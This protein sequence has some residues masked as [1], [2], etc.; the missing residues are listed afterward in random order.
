MRHSLTQQDDVAIAA[1][2]ARFM[3]HMTSTKNL[4]DSDS[5]FVVRDESGSRALVAE[6]TQ[7]A[8]ARTFKRRQG[9]S[10]LDRKVLVWAMI[11]SRTHGN[12]DI[13]VE[14]A[15]NGPEG[16]SDQYGAVARPRRCS[17]GVLTGPTTHKPMRTTIED[18]TC[19]SVSIAA[20]QATRVSACTYYVL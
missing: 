10:Q 2:Q 1:F 6:L 14:A 12:R 7:R 16:E 13:R 5:A 8:R 18:A 4:A 3:S 9:S 11:T 15:D 20:Q 17:S 19:S